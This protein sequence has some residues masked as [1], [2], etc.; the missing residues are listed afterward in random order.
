MKKLV[1]A[2]VA[3]LFGVAANAA[4]YNW[5][6]ESSWV[7]P[8]DN[9]ALSGATLYAFDANTYSSSTLLAALATAEDNGAAA[10]ANALGS[11]TVS[12]DGEVRASGSGLTDKDAVASMYG[13]LVIDDGS[14][15]LMSYLVD[16]ISDIEITSAITA[17]ASA[18]FDMGDV[19]T[20]DVG[21][22]GWAKIGGSTPPTPP[23]P[24]V[25]PEPTSGLLLLIGAAGLALKRKNA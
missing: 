1:I 16:G 17:G 23:T 24:P 22:D 4:T 7:S 18:I 3:M 13:L 6:L 2:A 14:G 21:G 12:D 25:I 15:G 5:R 19:V 8:D 11:G 20:G 10:L 9:D